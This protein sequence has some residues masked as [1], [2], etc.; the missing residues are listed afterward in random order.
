[1]FYVT[2]QIS[3]PLIHFQVVIAEKDIKQ[4]GT[5]EKVTKTQ[6][7]RNLFLNLALKAVAYWQNEFTLFLIFFHLLA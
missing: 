7:C 6:F 1:M 2:W 3:C 5:L 4:E